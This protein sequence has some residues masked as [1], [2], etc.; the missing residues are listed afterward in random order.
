MENYKV[1]VDGVVRFE[2]GTLKN[3]GLV[4][5]AVMSQV[6]G[7]KAELVMPEGETLANP[8][9]N[10]ALAFLVEKGYVLTGSESAAEPQ[11]AA[12]VRKVTARTKPAAKAPTATRKT[13]TAAAPR[14]RVAAAR[15]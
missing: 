9:R 2:C 3:A 6:V 7:V 12:P 5:D 14:K 8:S 13:A 10:E 4:Y 15:K 11:Q 1:K